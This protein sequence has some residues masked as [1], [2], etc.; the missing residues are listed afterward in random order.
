MSSAAVSVEH[1]TK[2]F[3]IPLDQTHRLKY[4]VSHP[5]STSRYRELL[6]VND[7]SFEVGRGEFLGITGPNGCGKSTLLKILSRI[8][9]ADSGRVSIRER[10]SPFLELGVGF[11]PEL[12]AREN[13]FLGGAVLGLTRKQLAERT[14]RLFEFAELTDFADQKVKNFS[15][16]MA[17]R[18][19]FSVAIQADAGI[20]LMDEVLAVGDARFQEKCFDVFAQYKRD[21]RTIVLVSHDLGSLERYCDRVLLLQK[22]R[23]VADGEASEVTAQYRRIVGAMSNAEASS[24]TAALAAEHRWGA[25]EVEVTGVRLLD[26]DGKPQHTFLTDQ[27]M[28]VAVDF[29][30][31]AHVEEFVCGLGFKRSDG[32]SLAGPNTKVARHRIVASEPGTCGTITYTIPEVALLGASYL[33]TVALYDVH[34]VHAFDHRDDMLEFRVADD[35]GRMGLVDLGGVWHDA[36][37]EVDKGRREAI[38]G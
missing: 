16:G 28:T 3:R 7:V 4:R 11:N 25:R 33:L 15:S 8:Y 24:G 14:E 21:N 31:N 36:A 10:V 19:A 22:G 34:L 17:V 32:I 27:P 29:R 37:I 35:K 9:T 6:A 23:L 26:G 13:I 30:V 12:T 1:V 2:R 38:A 18:L 5:I 20:L